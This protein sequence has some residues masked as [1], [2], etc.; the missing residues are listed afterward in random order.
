MIQWTQFQLRLYDYNS[1]H[2]IHSTNGVTT[3]KGLEGKSKNQG[4]DNRRGLILLTANM[5]TEIQ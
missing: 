1:K 2:R 4:A 5:L 3:I